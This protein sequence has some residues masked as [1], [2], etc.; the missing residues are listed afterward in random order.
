MPQLNDILH[1]RRKNGK[2]QLMLWEA[3]EECGKE[4][5]VNKRRWEQGK[6]R[7][8]HHCFIINHSIPLQGTFYKDKNPNWKGG[9]KK[10]FGY[11]LKRVYTSDRN[12]AIIKTMVTS[13]EYILLH[14]YIMAVV[15]GRPLSTKEIV[16]HLDGNR[17]N[18]KL[19]NLFLTNSH[20][21]DLSYSG[22]YKQ[23]FKDGIAYAS[24]L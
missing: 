21:H 5:W 11:I 7:I 14:R 6:Q 3:C 24:K 15:L 1:K 10:T 2:I 20:D 17:A 16:H 13:Q 18:N 12:F 19:K 22:G 4:R 8:C 9:F 23:G